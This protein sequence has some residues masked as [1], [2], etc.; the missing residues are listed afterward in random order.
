MGSVKRVETLLKTIDIGESE[1][2][3]LAQEMGAQLLIMDERK[4]RA[5]VN[6][7]NIKTTGILGLL[8]KAKEKN[9]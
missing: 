9:D 3:I 6:S 5:V 1:A 4:G 7:Y 8:I 2:I